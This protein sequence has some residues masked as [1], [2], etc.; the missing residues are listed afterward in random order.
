MLGK[1]PKAPIVKE[2][3]PFPEPL[4]YL[5]AWF[6]QISQ[7]LASGFGFPTITWETLFAWTHLIQTQLEP[8]EVDALMRLSTAR[9]S[10]ESERM[11]DKTRGNKGPNRPGRSHH[12]R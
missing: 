2:G 4:A 6:V 3:P 11:K 1:K 7:G 12:G 5:W 9:V 10:I 8:W